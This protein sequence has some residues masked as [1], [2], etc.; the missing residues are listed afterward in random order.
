MH[1]EAVGLLEMMV[2]MTALYMQGQSYIEPSIKAVSLQSVFLSALFVA[3]YLESGDVGLLFLSA[4]TLAMR[5]A[6]VPYMMLRQV[7]PSGRTLRETESSQRIASLIVVGAMVVM[8]GYALF[9][10]I[11]LPAV[12][13][14]SASV[15]FVLLLLSFLLIITRHNTL[16]Q[17]SGYLEEENAVL[18]FGALIAPGL[19]LL[20]EVAVALDIFGVV[21][22]GVIISA[23][24]EAFR[25]LEPEDLEQ[26]SG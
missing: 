6:V 10:L 5:G 11:L 13:A 12:S 4:I 17:M 14:P 18:L 1:S 20:M 15:A 3:L 23:E 19:P 24:R 7:R 22:V 16:V 25:T 9:T 26:L 21:L 2:V 8:A